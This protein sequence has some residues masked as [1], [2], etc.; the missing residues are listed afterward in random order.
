MMLG[1]IINCAYE[2]KYWYSCPIPM[3]VIP[4]RYPWLL[5]LSDP[6]GLI[7]KSLTRVQLVYMILIESNY[8]VSNA[9]VA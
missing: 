4:V 6:H 5:F 3:V 8:S 1:I 9:L 2:Y 7:E